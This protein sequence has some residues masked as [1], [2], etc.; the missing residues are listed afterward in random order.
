MACL[1]ILGIMVRISK[2]S[3]GTQARERCDSHWQLGG[4]KMLLRQCP[5]MMGGQIR[6]LNHQGTDDIF[7]G[8]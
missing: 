4:F 5:S 7:D 2:D 8:S 6:S 3:R 1:R